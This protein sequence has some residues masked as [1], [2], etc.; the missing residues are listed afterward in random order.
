[1]VVYNK[2][3]SPIERIYAYNGTEAEQAYDVEGNTLL[4]V[5][6]DIVV[7]TYN[8]QWFTGLN[9]EESMQREILSTYNPDIIGL[10]ELGASM[11][12]LGTTLFADY[13]EIELGSQ[14]NKTGCVSKYTF[15]S[16]TADVFPNQTGETR[17]YQKAYF[18]FNGKTICWINTH[19]ATSSYESE[20]VAQAGVLLSLV[21]NEEYF[22]ITGDF[23]TVCKSVN[24][25]EYTTIMKQFID[26]GYNSANCSNQH[27]FIDTWTGGKTAS[28]TWYPCDQIITSSNITINNV[29]ADTLKIE[30][31]GGQQVIDHIPLV[32]YM[33]V[34]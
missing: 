9:A 16:V 15:S 17:G 6:N 10:Q 5:S 19:L 34:S 7:M 21:Q 22:I 14:H 33:T 11:P 29:I 31:S 26:A 18:T 24:D 3:G 28:D 25:T 1:M 2:N 23:N 4:P 13:A 30:T 20:K 32:A 12:S 27:G 8:V